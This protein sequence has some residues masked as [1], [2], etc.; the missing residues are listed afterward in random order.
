MGVCLGRH[1]R[2]DHIRTHTRGTGHRWLEPPSAKR[3]SIDLH[4][5]QKYWEDG[6]RAW[7]YL[8]WPEFGWVNGEGLKIVFGGRWDDEDELISSSDKDRWKIFQNLEETNSE[9]SAVLSLLLEEMKNPDSRLSRLPVEIIQEIYSYIFS[10]WETHIDTTK[11]FG[12]LVQGLRH[13]C[14]HGGHCSHGYDYYL[15]RPWSALTGLTE[16]RRTD[17][18]LPQP[19]EFGRPCF[20]YRTGTLRCFPRPHQ[21]RGACLV[22]NVTFPAPKGV[23]C[24]MMPIRLG[25]P[26]SIPEIIKQ[27]MPLLIACIMDYSQRNRI[28]Y[29]TINESIISNDGQCHTGNH[30]EPPGKIWLGRYKDQSLPQVIFSTY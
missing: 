30:T 16:H 4:Q 13:D 14:I 3:T 28:G 5:C 18:L 10:Y 20:P 8:F 9:I 26:Y 17:L 29:I 1:R 24:N 7:V 21:F 25:S 6:V 2:G 12:H 19:L 11:N 15:H 23:N 22:S 27:Y